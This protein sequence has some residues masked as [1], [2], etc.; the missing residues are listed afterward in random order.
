[1]VRQKEYD[2]VYKKATAWENECIAA[3]RCLWAIVLEAAKI[4]INLRDEPIDFDEVKSILAKHG[5]TGFYDEA[6]KKLEND[7]E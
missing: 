5:F 2:Y 6:L 1:M 7:A 4:D 3:K